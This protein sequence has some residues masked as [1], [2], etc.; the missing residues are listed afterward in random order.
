MYIK[1][2]KL[3]LF[4]L[5]SSTKLSLNP[6]YVLEFAELYTNHCTVSTYGETIDAPT[7]APHDR[8]ESILAQFSA[9]TYSTSIWQISCNSNAYFGII[10]L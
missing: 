4:L 8:R 2:Y 10:S 1:I 3:T 6:D 5:Y 9:N 7:G